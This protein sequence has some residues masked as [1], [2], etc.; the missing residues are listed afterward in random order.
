MSWRT[1]KKLDM[2]RRTPK[3]IISSSSKIPVPTE[4]AAAAAPDI[5]PDFYFDGTI[6]HA[7]WNRL[8]GTGDIIEDAFVNPDP[9]SPIAA[10]VVSR[11]F[12]DGGRNTLT[13]D[14]IDNLTIPREDCEAKLR[15]HKLQG[16]IYGGVARETKEGLHHRLGVDA[17]QRRNIL[18]DPSGQDIT[19]EESR[20]YM[21]NRVTEIMYALLNS[22]ALSNSRAVR[23]AM[24]ETIRNKF[25]MFR[26]LENKSNQI[27]GPHA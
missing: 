2:S 21:V 27:E 3:N 6:R 8:G 14:V 13:I 24:V 12:G 4:Q 23:E 7:Q 25:V 20:N 15:L 1:R 19:D 16:G 5:K 22:D 9:A 17:R 11:F 18:V 10:I 26:Q